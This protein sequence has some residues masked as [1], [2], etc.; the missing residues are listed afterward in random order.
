MYEAYFHVGILVKDVE[1][2]RADFAAKLGLE[3]EPTRSQQLAT[4]ETTRFCYS[5]QG[6]PY[7]E[8]V[9]MTG[10]GS[11]S[12]EQ[13]EGFHHI[14]LS[15][16]SVPARCSAFGSGVDLIAP[17]PDGLPLVALTPPEALHGVRVEYFDA[18]VAA[19]FL[20][21]L[22]SRPVGALRSPFR[23]VSWARLGQECLRRVPDDRAVHPAWVDGD[24]RL[25]EVGE[26]VSLLDCGAEVFDVTAGLADVVRAVGVAVSLVPGDDRAGLEPLDGVQRVEPVLPAVL[27]PRRGTGSRLRRRHRLPRQA[28]WR[29]HA[30]RL[31]RSPSASKPATAS[32]IRAPAAA[33]SPAASRAAA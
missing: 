5:L 27:L 26:V 2:A 18:K 13:P 6:P 21:Y 8:L 14:G 32:P 20:G 33:L 7:L 29:G 3:F 9:E 1:A 4:G 24:H 22:S 17:G 15:D 30:G 10:S 11:W 12:A 31:T 16:P 28:R 25:V 23:L 19:Q